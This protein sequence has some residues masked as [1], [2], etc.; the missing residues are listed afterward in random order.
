MD[1]RGFIA[2]ISLAE[3]AVD[4][5]GGSWA[6]NRADWVGKKPIWQ[7]GLRAIPPSWRLPRDCA[8]RRR[9]QSKPSPAARAW[10]RQ[11]GP[12]P[13]YISGWVKSPLSFARANEQ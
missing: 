12:T 1:I 11:K 8:R 10:A 2:G 6:R 9:S 4:L 7:T 3:S 5:G 13:G